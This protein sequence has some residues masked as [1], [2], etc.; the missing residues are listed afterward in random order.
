MKSTGR[1]TGPIRDLTCSELGATLPEFALILFT[2]FALLF[3]I[4]QGGLIFG[5]WIVVTNA[6]RE[7]ARYGA[8]C[9]SRAE[10]PTSLGAAR[11]CSE[12]SWA[13]AAAASNSIVAY[14]R[15]R[16]AW[17]DPADPQFGVQIT[18]TCNQASGSVPVTV[19]TE[20]PPTAG[21]PRLVTVRVSYKMPILVPFVGDL[22]PGS[23]FPLSAE[24]AMRIEE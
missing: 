21:E 23:S 17:P 5:S 22:A 12:G 11:L 13:S 7:G 2:F 16:I 8:V 6:A 10:L 20:P 3:G 19:C 9:I 4:I 14:T 24:S 18:A 1:L 15:N